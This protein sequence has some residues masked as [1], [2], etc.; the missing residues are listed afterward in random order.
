MIPHGD[1]QYNATH[2]PTLH[3]PRARAIDLN[4]FASLH[5][6]L[7]DMMG[8]YRAGELAIVHR[9]GHP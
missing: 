1:P 4:G 5:P 8:A 7:Q 2:R 3:I 9:V 6:K